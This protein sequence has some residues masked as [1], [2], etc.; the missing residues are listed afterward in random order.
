MLCNIESN[1]LARLSYLIASDPGIEDRLSSITDVDSL[2]ISP[3]DR[4]LLHQ[5]LQ[6]GIS[7]K[8]LLSQ[9]KILGTNFNWWL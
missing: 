3:E 4:A 1:R 6:C 8:K 2:D 9:F 7:F 5:L